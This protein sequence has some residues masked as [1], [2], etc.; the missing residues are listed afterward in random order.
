[1]TN[2]KETECKYFY[3]NAAGE[4]KCSDKSKMFSDCDEYCGTY[5]KQLLASKQENKELKDLW[6]THKGKIYECD[7]GDYVFDGHCL[8]CDRTDLKEYSA[9][10]LLQENKKMREALEKFVTCGA[11]KEN[12]CPAD[13]SCMYFNSGDCDSYLATQALSQKEERYELE[14]NRVADRINPKELNGYGRG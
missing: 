5:Y 9:F 6:N 13:N 7:C 12:K 8:G 2:I 11:I 4:H 3:M 14:K 10:E 1:M